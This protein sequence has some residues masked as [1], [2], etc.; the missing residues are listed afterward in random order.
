M[1]QYSKQTI[2]KTGFNL[3]V[4]YKGGFETSYP[5]LQNILMI[6]YAR[7]IANVLMTAALLKCAIFYEP[8]SP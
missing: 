3:Y 5:E 6:M 8:H 1:A 7:S 4:I 2:I